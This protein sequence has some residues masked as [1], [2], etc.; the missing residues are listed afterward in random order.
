MKINAPL[1]RYDRPDA[2]LFITNNNSLLEALLHEA[3][4]PATDVLEAAE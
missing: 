4:E 3:L 2:S 1:S